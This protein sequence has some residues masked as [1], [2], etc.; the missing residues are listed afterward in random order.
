MPLDDALVRLLSQAA[1]LGATETLSTFD[2][3]GRV[4]ARELVSPLQVPPRDNSSRDGYA[5][6]VA[7][8]PDEGVAFAVSQRIPAGSAAQPLQPGTIARIFTGAAVPEG[9]DAIV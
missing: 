6:R 4:L 1:P 3:D 9:A 5:V 7:E 8:I 2:A